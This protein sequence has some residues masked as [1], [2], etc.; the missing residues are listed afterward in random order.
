MKKTITVL[1][2]DGIGAE[3][4]AE[5]VSV[6]K[7]I[8]EEFGHSFTIENHLIGGTAIRHTGS[9][10]P[11]AT[12]SAAMESDA[13]LLGAVGDPSY[14]TLPPDNRPEAG[15]LQLRKEMQTYAN[16]RPV[17]TYTALLER[18]P[19][20]LSRPVDMVIV[21]ELTGGLYFGEPRLRRHLETGERV[22]LNTLIY[23]DYEIARIAR[24]AFA[25]ARRR[26]R[27]VTSVDKAN[28]LE[29]SQLWREVV[30]EVSREFPDVVLE[31]LYVDNCAMQ[32]VLHPG[33]FDVI[34][35]E[36]MFG[37][38]LSD[39]AAVLTGSLGM[40]PSASLGDGSGLYE[41]VHGSAPDIAGKG[42][43]NP[44]GAILSAAMLLRHSLDMSE[45]AEI[46]ET[47]VAETVEL[48]IVTP[49]LGGTAGTREVGLMVQERIL[50]YARRLQRVE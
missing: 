16:L 44:I 43:A 6:L 15:L 26:R 9:P 31:H 12:L 5:A 47:A 8:A 19:V 29:V 42:I 48:G 2:G 25:L 37:D 21:R 3:V 50:A 41:P 49:D 17:T 38:I 40:L 35:T 30:T 14:N 1:A 24:V 10:L 46:V 27:K 22:A 36:N 45:E 7:L 20:R 39:E 11:K 28:V 34:L 18:S 4:T 13:V 23:N 32:I 33:A